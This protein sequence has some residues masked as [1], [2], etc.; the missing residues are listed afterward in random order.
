M[1]KKI[2]TKPCYLY[3]QYQEDET[4]IEF[5]KCLDDYKTLAYNN[6]QYQTMFY[7][8]SKYS[9]FFLKC[10]YGF[11]YNIISTNTN[12][13]YYDTDS[14]YDSKTNYDSNIVPIQLNFFN[15]KLFKRKPNSNR[16]FTIV[17]FC[18]IIITSINQKNTEQNNQ[19]KYSD[20]KIE[21]LPP[22]SEN[23]LSNQTLWVI[24]INKKIDLS[25]LNLIK[26]YLKYNKNHLPLC[27]NYNIALGENNG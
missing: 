4:M 16:V 24:K 1:L 11:N 18:E 2:Q 23:N 27:F 17:D 5:F 14:N 9:L 19:L 3:H 26:S 7:N 21:L 10:I 6:N 22:R 8:L 15:K 25:K 20:L 12:Q 13:H